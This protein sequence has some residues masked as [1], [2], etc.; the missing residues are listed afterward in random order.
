MGVFS[1]EVE[2]QAK[3]EKA[4]SP[5]DS[6]A[7]AQPLNAFFWS[8]DFMHDTLYIGRAFRTFNVVDDYIREVLPS[9]L[10]PICLLVEL[11]GGIMKSYFMNL[12]VK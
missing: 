12:S 6:K 7:V 5:K 2:H 4:L 10:I 8:I 3:G 1:F 9:G 11:S